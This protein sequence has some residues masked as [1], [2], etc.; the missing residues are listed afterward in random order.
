M[1]KWP[2]WLLI[3]AVALVA[4]AL[5]HAWATGIMEPLPAGATPEQA[6]SF[7]RHDSLNTAMFRGAGMLFGGAGLAAVYGWLVNRS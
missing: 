5:I 6:A 1:W 4:V 3:A 2:L 7:T